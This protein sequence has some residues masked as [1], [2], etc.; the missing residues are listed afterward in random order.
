M[1]TGNHRLQRNK[2]EE[3]VPSSFCANPYLVK[4][5]ESLKAGMRSIIAL[6]QTRRLLVATVLIAEFGV[7]SGPKQFFYYLDISTST[8]TY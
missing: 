2:N 7:F 4:L 3:N 1:I 6:L 5:F 8:Y